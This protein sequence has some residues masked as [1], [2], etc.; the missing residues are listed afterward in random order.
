MTIGMMSQGGRR[1]VRVGQCWDLPAWEA[2][3][4]AAREASAGIDPRLLVVF[5]S[6][7]YDLRDLLDGVA[8][9]AGD[10]PV[11]GC[12]TSGEIGPGATLSQGVVVVGF[13]G[14][15]A[16]RTTYAT[17]LQERARGVGE[18]VAA[19]LLPLPD[20]RHGVVLML[21]DALCGDQQEMIRGAYGILG[22]TVPLIGG[23]A[24]DNMRM[25]TS[26]Q[27]HGGK[28]FQD[29]VVAAH[30]G[31]DGPLGLAIRHGWRCEGPAM[32]VTA[33]AGNEVHELD[34][35]PALDVYLDLHHAPAGIE[36]DA[37][38][39][40]EYALT[41]PLAIARR[42]DIAVRHVMG[43]DPDTR[44]LIC[45]GGVPK[46]AAAWLASGD[47]ES[48]LAA[49]D[50][51]CADAIDGLGGAPLLALLVFDCA[52]RRALL[53]DD[54]LMIEHEAMQRRAGSAALAGFYTY[55]EVGRIKGVIGFHNQTI[56]A[57]ALG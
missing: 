24:G 28:I 54:G 50:A 19:A 29:G 41:R 26:R 7:S 8:E 48:N 38:S 25:L 22:A 49:A 13:G 40:A 20:T 3:A 42:G 32:V 10:V 46:G 4:K 21:T 44:A 37:P 23:G 47:V 45:A 15:F 16:V 51:A 52:G 39:F 36:R 1:W 9:V 33:T 2:G 55:G 17:G 11:I 57:L 30:I 6:F 43:A 56:V 35:R 34:D 5:A 53:G 18:D 14:D 31:T 27:F 12:S